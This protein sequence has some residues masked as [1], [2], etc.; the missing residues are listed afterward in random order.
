MAAS[1]MADCVPCIRHHYQKA[2][3]AGAT[4]TEISEALAIAMAI[5]AGSKKAKYEPVIA[6]LATDNPSETKMA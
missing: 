4:V 3:A 2:V 5:A 6:E 1:V